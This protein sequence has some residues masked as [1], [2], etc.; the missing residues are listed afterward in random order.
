MLND[1]E[2]NYLK[3]ILIGSLQL[4]SYESKQKWG[5]KKNL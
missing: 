2:L 1:F 3:V 5:F 4:I